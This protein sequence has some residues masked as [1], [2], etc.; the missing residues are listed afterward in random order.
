MKVKR[1][2]PC[3]ELGNQT[4][5]L[6][7]KWSEFCTIYTA[8]MESVFAKWIFSCKIKVPRP[9]HPNAKRHKT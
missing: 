7:C 8:T 9:K 2:M 1:E 3:V 4:K 5:T 6:F